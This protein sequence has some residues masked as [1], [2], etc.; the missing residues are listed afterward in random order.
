MSSGAVSLL[1]DVVELFDAGECGARGLGGG[2]FAGRVE[3]E[4]EGHAHLRF[5]EFVTAQI[6]RAGRRSGAG[7]QKQGCQEDTLRAK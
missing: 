6:H 1:F 3:D 5:G 2:R 7:G 4:A